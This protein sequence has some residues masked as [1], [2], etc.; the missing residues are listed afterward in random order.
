[1][2]QTPLDDRAGTPA[3]RGWR[4][5][6]VDL[7][8]WDWGGPAE[9]SEAV[10]FLHG[11]LN[12][13]RVWDPILRR[14]GGSLRGSKRLAAPD[15]RG[16]GES[17]KPPTGYSSEAG[18][19]EVVALLDEMGVGRASLVGHSRGGWL[20]AAVASLFPERISQVAI[21]E[22]SPVVG[23]PV[24]EMRAHYDRAYGRVRGFSSEAEA[25]EAART[26]PYPDTWDA[27]REAG[28]WSWLERRDGGT[29]VSKTPPEAMA[30]IRDEYIASPDVRP[31]LANITEPALVVMA[32]PL[33]EK[34]LASR[35]EVVQRLRAARVERIEG[36]HWLM[37]A[38]PDR[39]SE[40]LAD[41]LT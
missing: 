29:I 27:D 22:W 4:H 6:D 8:W 5:D 23:R 9:A 33:P 21:V 41:F 14:I 11:L 40:L 30:A 37:Y 39:L 12:S 7:A 18:A 35:M 28:L 17:A 1:M 20:I 16:H 13:G 3:R 24:D 26:L 10:V 32:E 19:R 25:V 2:M 34:E 15:M 36:P 38:N 31:G